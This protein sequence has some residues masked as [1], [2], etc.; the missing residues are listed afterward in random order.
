MGIKKNCWE[1]TACGREPGGANVHELGICPAAIARDCDG[2][3]GGVCGGRACWAISGTLCDGRLQGTIASK[4]KNCLKCEFYQEVLREN[5]GKGN[6]LT[7]DQILARH[8]PQGIA[9]AD[10]ANSSPAKPFTVLV[11]ADD[12]S[13]RSNLCQYLERKSCQVVGAASPQEAVDQAARIEPDIILLTVTLPDLDGFRTL[14]AIR[15]LAHGSEIPIVFITTSPNRAMEEQGVKLGAP[16]IMQAWASNFWDELDQKITHL[17]RLKRRMNGLSALVLDPNPVSRRIIGAC[18]KQQG[19]TVFQATDEGEAKAIARDQ[20]L[21]LVIAEVFGASFNGL[22]FCRYLRRRPKFST[23]PIILLC[24]EQF[25]DKII[26]CFQAGATDYIIKPCPREELLA[27]LLIHI[28][29]QQR[30]KKLSR[31]VDK[32]KLLLDSIGEGIIGIDSFGHVTFVNQ[33]AARMLGYL[34]DD[35]LGKN[36]DEITHHTS[37]RSET[38]PA[39]TCPILHSLEHGKIVTVHDDFFW[40]NDNSRLPVKYIATPIIDNEITY[41]AVVAFSDITVEKREEEQRHDIERITRHD[42]KT[43]LNGIIGI[44]AVLLEDGNLNER[45]VSLLELLRDSGYRMLEMISESLNMFKMEKGTYEFSPTPVDLLTT[46]SLIVD[47][48]ALLKGKGPTVRIT[49]GGKPWTPGQSFMVQGEQLL[50]YSMLANLIKNAVEASPPNGTLDIA[51]SHDEPLSKIIIHNQGVVPQEIRER[52]FDKYS[53]AGKLNGT[54]LGTYSAK[55]IV[56]T[57]KGSLSMTT[58]QEGGTSLIIRL[59]A[60]AT[61]RQEIGL[62]ANAGYSSLSAGSC[63]QHR[64]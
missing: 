13:L 27:R 2:I 45:Q 28:E 25:R 62:T 23:T 52:F 15:D 21:D 20:H 7:S 43:P 30:L 60:V 58:D 6:F 50:C 18:L 29:S 26:R 48:L 1:F 3:H 57:H 33:T 22:D 41:G 12:P 16:V 42:L 59:P 46:I 32:N 39:I 5:N 9:L 44:P 36:L 55:L 34:P 35:L 11:K 17:L 14:A 19:V 38:S 4:L 40:R 47:E 24:P 49:M 53:T 51:L 63:Y 10:D 37:T 61:C 56:E 31:E 54:G 64:P 8:H